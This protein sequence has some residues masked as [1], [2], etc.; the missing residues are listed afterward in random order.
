MKLFGLFI[1]SILIFCGWAIAAKIDTCVNDK[2]VNYSWVTIEMHY[3]NGHSDTKTFKIQTDC[4][5]FTGI[6][7]EANSFNTLPPELITYKRSKTFGGLIRQFLENNVQQFKILKI[8][9]INKI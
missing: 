2:D 7:Q 1:I 5:E 9:H 6:S 3:T 4:I 8:K